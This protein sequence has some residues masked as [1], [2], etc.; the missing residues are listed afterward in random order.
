MTITTYEINAIALGPDGKMKRLFTS[1]AMLTLK[2]CDRQVEI[3]KKTYEY[4]LLIS[5]VKVT[6]ASGTTKIVHLKEY[7]WSKYGI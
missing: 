6:Y 1:T 4:K 7:D 2:E 3:W 5:W